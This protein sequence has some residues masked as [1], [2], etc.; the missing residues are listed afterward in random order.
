MFFNKNLN[1]LNE[2]STDYIRIYIKYFKPDIEILTY[3]IFPDGKENITILVN[4]NE[5]NYVLRLSSMDRSCELYDQSEVLIINELNFMTY[6]RNEGVS[7][8]QIYNTIYGKKYQIINSQNEKIYI[9][10]MEYILSENTEY[11]YEIVEKIAFTQYKLHYSAK[12]IE[13]IPINSD[14]NGYSAQSFRMFG[15]SESDC[16]SYKELYDIYLKTRDELINYFKKCD[17][18]PIH[19]DIKLDNIL[20]KN[21][22]IKAVID[23]GDLRISVIAEDI[24]I[25]IWDLCDK[26]YND[27]KKFEEYVEYYL[28][29]YKYFNKSI[30][31][32][33]EIMAINYAIDRYLIINLF[34]LK[35]NRSDREQFKYQSDKANKQFEIVKRLIRLKQ[36]KIMKW[37]NENE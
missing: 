31:C 33:D 2:L 16:C 22:E 11:S 1:L 32:I 4:T 24:G 20:I 27:N 19:A 12:K 21:K 18:I 17:K 25:L 29:C 23:F 13:I 26:L 30:T 9:I 3:N 28:K 5:G 34:Y 15:I 35:K 37:K 7:I 8:P 10:L 14:F 36:T 6:L